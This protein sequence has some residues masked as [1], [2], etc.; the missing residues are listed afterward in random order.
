MMNNE[1]TKFDGASVVHDPAYQLMAEI[2][3]ERSLRELAVYTCADAA[4]RALNEFAT[5]RPKGAVA[6][7]VRTVRLLQ[8][9]DPRK[10]YK[11]RVELI[12]PP[13]RKIIFQKHPRSID[14]RPQEVYSINTG[15]ELTPGTLT[16]ARDR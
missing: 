6:V 9:G 14:I 12:T 10:P 13:R 16:K 15:E 7:G 1:P 8:W 2:A 3:G 11:Y 5:N 4:R